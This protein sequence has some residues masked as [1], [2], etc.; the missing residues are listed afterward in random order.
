M[1]APTHPAP[2]KR[3]RLRT[4][5]AVATLAVV[6]LIAAIPW[7]LSTPPARR[8][9]VGKANGALAPGGL[10]VA[11]WRLSWFGPTR[12]TGLVLRDRQGDRVV[13]APSA[14]W[15]RNLGQILFDR[16]RFGTLD[17]GP[18]ALDVERRADGSVDLYEAL[19]P[20]LTGDPRTD[21]TI[22]IAG[23]SFRLRSPGLSRPVAADRADLM[24]RIPAAPQP[25]SW[26]M[27]L[28]A[29]APD[30]RHETPDTRHQTLTVAGQLD[31]G[32]QGL[33][34]EPDLSVSLAGTRWPL[35]LQIEGYAGSARLDGTI[36]FRRRAGLW[37]SSGTAALLDL[38]AAGPVLAGDRLR[39]DRVAASWDVSRGGHAWT[40]R[41]LQLTTAL[42]SLTSSGT[43]PAAAG[44]STQV[45]G[46]LDLAALARQLPHALQ[47]PEGWTPDRGSV[48]LRIVVRQEGDRPAWDIGARVEDLAWDG[49]PSS[50]WNADSDLSAHLVPGPDG[51][52][53]DGRLD[54]HDPTPPADAAPGRDRSFSLEARALY[55]DDPEQVE[56]SELVLTGRDYGTLRASGRLDDPEGR[57][58]IDLRGTL[59][60]DWEA[61]NAVLTARVEPGARVEGGP[62]AFA[63][64]GPLASGPV[65]E[66]WKGLDA[67][68]EVDLRAA[69]VFGLHVGPATIAARGEAGRIAL[70]PIVSTLNEGRLRIEPELVLDGEDGPVLRLGP[71]T[72]VTD[73][74]VNE[75][76][77]RRV[78][79][80]V[81]PVLEQA[82]RP[83]G[84]VSVA[85]TRAEIPLDTEGAA[86]RAVVEGSVVFRDVEFAPGPLATDLLGLIGRQD[87]ILKLDEP[88]VLSVADG[89]VYQHGLGIPLGN[90]SRIELEGSVDFDRNLDLTA[91]L[92]ITAAL[93]GDRPLL[94]DI[95][96]GALVTVP[97]RGTLSQPRIDRQALGAHMKDLGKTLLTRG[98]VR[99]ASELLFRLTRP[100]DPD[101]PPPPPRLTP[102]E[103]KDQRLQRN[104]ERRRARQRRDGTP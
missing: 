76:V 91:R 92:P 21:L 50:L 49:D 101:A 6:A 89:R 3:R 45:T 11:S 33:A 69:T 41:G 86:H 16:P 94:A 103:R 90:V 27:A 55:R 88:V 18:A 43:L 71:G 28:A 23:G 34:G 39:L 29:S 87:A 100:R 77:S 13:V 64:R 95:A 70:E 99:G 51:L 84:K 68:V 82:T 72:A 9:L 65:A 5:L 60:P 78:L 22:R 14:S 97:I 98:A 62:V 24:L 12:L 47:V 93:L 36:G 42:G 56:L 17:L 37:S 73:A 52:R 25:V 66:I 58:L 46:R 63:V 7:A 83:R 53:I 30:T 85:I 4:A 74:E 96:E 15:D 59:D 102:Q 31:R 48:D 2:R 80:F 40:I 81:A 32:R 57:R 104:E 19:R 26:Q 35:D 79:A 10:D 61:I 54:V 67:A 75:E 38:D 1:S 8:W 20:I 44:T